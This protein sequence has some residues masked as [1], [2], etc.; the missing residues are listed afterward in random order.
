M[1]C[2]I[3]LIQYLG[4][5][6]TNYEQLKNYLQRVAFMFMIKSTK[7][8]KE[9]TK[10]ALLFVFKSVK[11]IKCLFYLNNENS[12]GPYPSPHTVFVV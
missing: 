7:I 5:K 4:I 6:Y 11:L 9:S 10:E 8:T 2:R 1:Y 3:K 12:P